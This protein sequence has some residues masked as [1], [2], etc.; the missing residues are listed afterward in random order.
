M[1]LFEKA[2]QQRLVCFFFFVSVVHCTH[3]LRLGRYCTVVNEDSDELKKII[4]LISL[5][6]NPIVPVICLDV[7]V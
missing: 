4:I 6:H 1:V 2:S 3:I 5:T 7:T